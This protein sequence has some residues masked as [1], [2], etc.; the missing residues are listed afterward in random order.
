MEVRV[1]GTAADAATAAASAIVEHL[2]NAVVARG[3][4]TLALSGGRTPSTMVERLAGSDVPWPQV[5]LFQVDERAVAV[6]DP[7]RNWA[8]FAPLVRLLPDGHAHP[9]PVGSA[10]DDATLLAAAAAYGRTLARVAGQ[11][12]ELDV[13]HLGLGDDGHTASLPPGDPVVQVTDRDV[14][15]TAPYRGHRRVTLT[16]PVL[17]RARAVVWLVVGPGKADV[18]RRLLAGEPALVGSLVG[19]DRAVVVLDAAAAALAGRTG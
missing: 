1:T 5:H 10:D 2:R 13:V 4:A 18:A 9:V 8:T 17:D 7:D 16:R 3:T 19:R 6:D 12:V 15:V 14:A 11:P